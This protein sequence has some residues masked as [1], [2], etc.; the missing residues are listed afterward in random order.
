MLSANNPEESAPIPDSGRFL[1]F[2]QKLKKLAT[3]DRVLF[4]DLLGSIGPTSDRAW[5]VLLL[6]LKVIF[7]SKSQDL[8]KSRK[9]LLN[10]HTTIQRVHTKTWN[11][12]YL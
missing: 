5:F 8:I 6:K 2:P 10:L 12:T 4:M 1:T 7:R 11:T 9:L 3:K